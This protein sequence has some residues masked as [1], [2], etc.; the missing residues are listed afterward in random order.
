M[1]AAAREADSVSAFAE[2]LRRW[3]SEHAPQGSLALSPQEQV[4]VGR[5]LQAELHRAGY[6]GIT[7]PEDVGGRG[8]GPA[9]QQAFNE[10]AAEFRLPLDAFVIGSGTCGPTIADLGTQQQKQRYLPAILRGEDI[11]C[12]LFSEPEAGSD[13]ASLRTKAVRDGDDWVI[14]GHKV[15][16]SN[17]QFADRG[18][19]L[20]RTDPDVVKHAGITMFIIDMRAAG[21]SVR[22]L[23]DMTGRAPFNEVRLDGVRLG[24]D[25][26]LGE[27]GGGWRATQTMLSHERATIGSG[28]PA[29]V[30]GLAYESL[31]GLVRSTGTV[32]GESQRSALAELYAHER[33][34]ALTNER[35]RHEAAA[36][37]GSSTR[38]SAAKLAGAL[39]QRRAVEVAGQLLGSAVAAWEPEDAAM[40][41]LALGI[42]AAPA[43][44][45]AGGTNEIQRNIIGERLLGLPREPQADRGLPFRASLTPTARE[46]AGL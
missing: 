7:W 12:Q 42:C 38:G 43:S 36:G 4:E 45:L 11:W 27:V 1:D 35:F 24:Q 21:V 33:A 29:R 46:G 15:W 30:S 32:L 26:V 20:A 41:Q 37:I 44:S 28:R 2:S 22:P 6:A 31:T 19:L 9:E 16:T 25:A 5:Q 3:L 13:L 8:R 23:K 40:E 39:L 17:A 34:L 14:S 10:L 18:A